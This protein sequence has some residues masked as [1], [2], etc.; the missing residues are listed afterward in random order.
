MYSKTNTTTLIG[1]D[2]KLVEVESDIT[3]GLH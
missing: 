2:G 3:S 1:L